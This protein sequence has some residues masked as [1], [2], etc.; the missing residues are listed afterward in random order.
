MRCFTF[1]TKTILWAGLT[2]LLVVTSGFSRESPIAPGK[3][4]PTFAVKYGNTQGWPP[5]AEAACFDLIDVS[6]SMSNTRVHASPY[7]NT[8]QN[9]KRLNPHM[10]IYLYKNGPV[11]SEFQDKRRMDASDGWAVVNP[12]RTDAMSV[13]VPGGAKA[14]VLT[15]DTFQ[16]SKKQPLVRYFDLPSHRGIILLKPERQIG[17]QDNR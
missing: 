5:A 13:A 3:F 9:L 1:V 17:N 8:W 10:K 14:R 12:T 2:L 6:S 11:I 15:H 16:Q 4:I 7:G